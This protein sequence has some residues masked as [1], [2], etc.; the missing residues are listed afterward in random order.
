MRFESFVKNNVSSSDS[1]ATIVPS[2]F[3]ATRENE[4]CIR[5]FVNVAA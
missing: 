3:I 2:F 1:I 4:R 5:T